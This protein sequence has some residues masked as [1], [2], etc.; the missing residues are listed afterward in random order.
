[1]LKST[2]DLSSIKLDPVFFETRCA[3]VVDVKL[4]VSTI[5]DSQYETESVF[6]L[7]CI[8]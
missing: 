3:H 2:A 8:C 6:G 5:H 1:M 4:Q 7:I